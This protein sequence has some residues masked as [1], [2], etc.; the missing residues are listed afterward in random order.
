PITAR[1][2]GLGS[3]P[4]QARPGPTLFPYTTLFRSR[5][6]RPAAQQLVFVVVEQGAHIVA[7]VD[8]LLECAALDALPV[9]ADPSFLVKY[10]GVTFNCP[11]AARRPHLH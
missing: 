1:R 9:A 7:P 8:R 2:M 11:A 10:C 6:G 4:G 3:L 5:A